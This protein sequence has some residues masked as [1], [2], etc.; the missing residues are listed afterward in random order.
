VEQ[1]GLEAELVAH[2]VPINGL[3]CIFLSHVQGRP[4]ITQNLITQI[5]HTDTLLFR[6]AYKMCEMLRAL[7]EGSDAPAF[8]DVATKFHR[9]SKAHF[10]F[11]KW[12]VHESHISGTL[13][14]EG[15]LK[16]M[17]KASLPHDASLERHRIVDTF[18][19]ADGTEGDYYLL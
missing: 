15:I 18:E 2:I 8:M 4:C 3:H 13:R 19:V 10:K 9:W 5:P 12:R 7:D 14:A 1:P 11:I 16:T 17:T 6:T